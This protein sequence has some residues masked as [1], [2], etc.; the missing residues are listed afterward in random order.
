[1]QQQFL[2]QHIVS[3]CKEHATCILQ[4]LWVDPNVRASRARYA[5]CLDALILEVRVVLDTLKVYLPDATGGHEFDV[6]IL[7]LPR[8]REEDST[9]QDTQLFSPAWRSIAVSPAS[10]RCYVFLGSFRGC[11]GKEHDGGRTCLSMEWVYPSLQKSVPVPGSSVAWFS[12]RCSN[13]VRLP[14]TNRFYAILQNRNLWYLWSESQI[15][16][17]YLR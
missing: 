15:F 9:Y 7:F 8:R 14:R 12:S 13:M 5:N 4:V 11:K 10:G 2:E 17:R 3:L 1:M 6:S 16:L